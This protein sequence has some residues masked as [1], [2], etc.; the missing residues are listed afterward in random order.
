MSL[1][2]ASSCCCGVECTCPVETESPTS[3]SLTI[4]VTGCQGTTA[5]VTCVLLLTGD[6]P[7]YVG[8]C[9]CPKYAFTPNLDTPAGCSGKACNFPYDYFDFCQNGTPDPGQAAIGITKAALGTNGTG[10]NAE[11]YTLCDIWTLYLVL[12]VKGGLSD[13]DAQASSDGGCQDCHWFYPPFPCVSWASFSVPIGFWKPTGQD[14]RGT[15]VSASGTVLDF[16]A[17]DPP[18]CDPCTG[19]YGMTINNITVA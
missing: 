7:C 8:A 4:T 2:A 10:Y 1:M 9:L 14:P 18:S 5:V 6:A 15:Y 12:E 11:P 16:C 13:L 3:V 19:Y 17:V